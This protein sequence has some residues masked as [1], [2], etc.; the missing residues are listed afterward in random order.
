M[1]NCIKIDENTWRIEDGS[2]R[3]YLLC[4]SQKAALID[5]GMNY[6]EA[7]NLAESITSLPLILINTHADPDHISGN[8]AFKEFYMSPKE[9]KNYRA[10]KGTGKILPVHEGDVIDLGERDLMIIDMPGHTP[11]SIAILDKKYRVLI[12][13]DSVQNS[14]IFMYGERRNLDQ[15]I[16]SL[17]H[18]A[19]FDSL[20]DQIYPMHGSFP[21]QKDLI[22]KLIEGAQEIKD[23]KALA[24]ATKVSI[25][26]NNVTFY[27]FDYAGFL[28]NPEDVA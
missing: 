22:S 1:K 18:L 12:S 8:G 13:G 6:P 20:Y 9:E 24:R 21:V 3:F 23:G 28:C 7:K 10:H 11:G 26:G 2:V 16:K 19:Q 17:R 4:G 15:Y 5:T 25:F 14:H 27:K